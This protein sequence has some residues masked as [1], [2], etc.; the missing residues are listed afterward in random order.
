[1]NK[2]QQELYEKLGELQWMMDRQHRMRQMRYGAGGD[3]ARGQ[4]RVLTMLHMQDNISSKDLAYVM[5]IRP[6]S[7]NELLGKLEGKGLIERSPSEEDKRVVMVRLTEEGKKADYS[8]ENQGEIFDCLNE[9]EQTQLAEYLDRILSS[10]EEKMPKDLR[11]EEESRQRMRRRMGGGQFERL[12]EMRR[13]GYGR[14]PEHGRPGRPPHGPGPRPP[15]GP[16][17]PGEECPPDFPED[18]EDL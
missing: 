9:Q 12:D 13:H 10:M 8:G 1:L 18:A 17:S 7:L 3:P 16:G 5:G 4:G 15:H 11:E 14:P 6:Q 2:T